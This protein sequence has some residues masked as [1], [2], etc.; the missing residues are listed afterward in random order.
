[1]RRTVAVRRFANRMNLMPPRE[2]RAQLRKLISSFIT[3]K[4]E[5]IPNTVQELMTADVGGSNSV[6]VLRWIPFHMAYLLSEVREQCKLP[7][8]V[9]DCLAAIVCAFD[10]LSTPK[11]E[12]G[13]AWEA[14]FL[15]VLLVRCLSGMY[16]PK[17]LPLQNEVGN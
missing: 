5:S 14:M 1:M 11:E 13:D 17:V 12:S 2:A 8:N 15:I 16:E 10:Q 6:V 9:N 4:V 3:G 7:D